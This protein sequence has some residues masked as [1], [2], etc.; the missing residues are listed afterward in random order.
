ESVPAGIAGVLPD[1]RGGPEMP[2]PF[3]EVGICDTR[4]TSIG[5][6]M[7]LNSGL[8]Q[9][10]RGVILGVANNRSIAWGIAKAC[11]AA[12]AEVALTWQGNALK[13]RVEPLANVLGGMLAGQCDVT[14]PATT[15]TVFA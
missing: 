11:H 15:A 14:S 10:K 4:A 9:G 6:Q 3:G 7:S 5:S 8:M 12:G 2:R 1:R 13:Q